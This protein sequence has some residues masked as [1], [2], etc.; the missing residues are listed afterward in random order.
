MKTLLR[1]LAVLGLSAVC[2]A[3]NSTGYQQLTV[4]TTAVAISDPM[5]SS[6]T[7]CRGRLASAPVNV[8]WSGGSP[9]STFG[10]PMSIGDDIVLGN[11]IDIRNFRAIQS[12]G[13]SGQLN[14]TCAAATQETSS[15]IASTQATVSNL[16][17]CNALYRAYGA[18]CR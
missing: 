12:G 17:V 18:A 14:I 5:Q 2:L 9:T 7:L 13:S 3:Q 16:P 4:S 15:Y 1:I 11:R 6:S 10:Q 8:L